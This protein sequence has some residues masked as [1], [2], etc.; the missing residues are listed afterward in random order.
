[1]TGPA[2]A[3]PARREVRRMTRS[4]RGLAAAAPLFG[5]ALAL[6]AGPVLNPDRFKPWVDGF[7]ADDTELYPGAIPNAQAWAFLR[8]NV[9]DFECP[10]RR[11]EELYYFRWWTYRKHI[12]A[13]P[14]GFVITEFLPDVPWA[15][16]DNT[17][18]CAAGH[19]FYEG[20]WLRDPAYLDDYA[21]FWL[22]R[23]GAPRNYSFWIADSLWNRFLTTGDPREIVELL[24]DLVENYRGWEQTNLGDDGLFWQIDDRDGMEL[25]IGD[26]NY[27]P[28]CRPT[29]NTYM[30]ADARAIANIA[31]LAGQPAVS[32]QFA[33][34]ADRLKLLVE[35]RLWDPQ[36]E[37]FKYLPYR[38]EPVL[39]SGRELFG[40]TPWYANLPDAGYEAAWRQVSDPAGFLAPFGL[41][42]AERRAPGFRLAYG[43][44]E[45][46]WNGPSWPFATSVTLTALANLLNNYHQAVVGKR[47]YFELLQTYTLAQHRRL[48]GG[49]VVP[50]IDEDLDPL[51][52]EW[53]ARTILGRTGGRPPER[54]KDYNH[55]TYCDLIISGLA[56][57]RPREDDTVEVNPLLPDNTWDYFC[58]DGVRYHGRM[59]TILFDRTGRRYGFGPGLRVLAAGRQIAASD[60]LARVAGRLPPD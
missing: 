37:F 35:R 38:R 19:H 24:P 17:I 34:R 6:A 7:N 4:F 25:P 42:T 13:T 43:G 47:D 11:F 50:W 15:G 31:R 18:S 33:A 1:M 26:C 20:R 59:L 51:T 44:H 54:G 46:Q 27:K 40:Y 41:T 10:D 48:P 45:C 36:A 5:A 58:L 2:S 32:A 21:V 57:L 53:I 30:Y 9:P 39:S 22:R 29:I 55:S 52:G 49:K 23:G 28:A 8:Q 3:S 12:K 16:K 60:V 56:G 14:D